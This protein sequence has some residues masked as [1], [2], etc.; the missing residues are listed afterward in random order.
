MSE[1]GIAAE[2]LLL[3]LLLLLHLLLLHQFG[4]GSFQRKNPEFWNLTEV[5]EILS[6]KKDSIE[7]EKRYDTFLSFPTP[8]RAADRLKPGLRTISAARSET[9]RVWRCS[10]DTCTSLAR[11]SWRTRPA[12]HSPYTKLTTPSPYTKPSAPSP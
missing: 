5:F 12:C 6:G 10:A 8:C 2:G 9:C 4:Q 3:L 7:S 1:S 11:M